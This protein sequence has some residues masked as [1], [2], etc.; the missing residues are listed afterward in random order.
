MTTDRDRVLESE[1][2]RRKPG[3]LGTREEAI[4]FL[5]ACLQLVAEKRLAC[6]VIIPDD[7]AATVIQ[8]RMAFQTYLMTI[9]RCLGAAETLF[10]VGKIDEGT[11]REF[12]QRTLNTLASTVVGIV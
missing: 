8:Q 4:N 7:A 3:K 5:D 1:Q 9:G 6:D 2:T 11:W 10:K 12:H